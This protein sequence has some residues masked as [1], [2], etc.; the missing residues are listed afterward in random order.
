MFVGREHAGE[1]WTDILDLGMD[2]RLGVEKKVI[3]D[4]KGNGEFTCGSM[5]VAVWVR[6][7]APERELFD[8]PL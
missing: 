1:T 3:I 8:L 7:D 6:K 2:R 5:S 4:W